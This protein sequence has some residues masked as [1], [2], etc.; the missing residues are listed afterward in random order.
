MADG[1]RFDLIILNTAD[2]VRIIRIT[3]M[4]RISDREYEKYSLKKP[5]IMVIYEREM[6]KSALNDG[7]NI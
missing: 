1:S 7:E 3:T 4:L 5:F 6:K 2:A